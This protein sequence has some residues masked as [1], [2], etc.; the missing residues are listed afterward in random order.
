VTTFRFQDVRAG[1]LLLLARAAVL[2]LAT[3]LLV[4]LPLPVLG[5]LLEPRRP[6][7]PDPDRWEQVPRLVDVAVRTLS[8]AVRPGCLTRGLTAY[9]LLRRAGL[10]V[11][12]DFGVGDVDGRTEAHCWL[13]RDGEPFAE[14]TD[15][16]PVFTAVA[17]LPMA[18]Q[19]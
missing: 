6:V 11:S 3:P 17:R 1:E 13:V 7:P 2:A 8:P 19:L 9:R 18:A 16:R 15:P 5:R 12:L 14:R 10:P 4:R